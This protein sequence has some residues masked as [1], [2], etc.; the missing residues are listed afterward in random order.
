MICNTGR[1]TPANR[2]S[3]PVA[4][5]GARAFYS[6]LLGVNEGNPARR[7]RP[8]TENQLPLGVAGMHITGPY[9]RRIPPRAVR[10]VARVLYWWWLRR[11]SK[12]SLA[13]AA[14]AVT[15]TRIYR[16]GPDDNHSP[17]RQKES[18]AALYYYLPARPKS[19]FFFI[20]SVL[21]SFPS[22]SYPPHPR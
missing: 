7:S 14:T 5:S 15:E 11:R 2:G 3:L 18:L 20:P 1:K 12:G 10:S 21:Y 22:D 8:R 9:A 13:A 4:L 6:Y 16:T 17:G 19:E